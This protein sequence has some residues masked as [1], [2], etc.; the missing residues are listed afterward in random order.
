[1]HDFSVFLLSRFQLRLWSE[2]CPPVFCIAGRQRVLS[3]T[4]DLTRQPQGMSR[5]QASADNALSSAVS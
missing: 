3:G 1:M 2:K 5:E 4:L